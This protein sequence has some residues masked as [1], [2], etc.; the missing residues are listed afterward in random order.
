MVPDDRGRRR[1]RVPEQR[2]GGVEDAAQ[3]DWFEE[4]IAY[5]LLDGYAQ[6]ARELDT[7][8][9]LGENFYGPRA[10][11]RAIADMCRRGAPGT[12]VNILSTSMH[13]GQRNLAAYATTKG[14]LASST[15][16]SP[17]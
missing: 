10:M 4:P 6:L 13:V 5:D 2:D 14:G 8:V 12:I 11:Q 17:N 16:A 1:G 15:S 3:I 9:Q 7:P